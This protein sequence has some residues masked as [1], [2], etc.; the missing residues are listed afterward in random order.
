MQTRETQR[1]AVIE[2]NPPRTPAAIHPTEHFLRR[3]SNKHGT[4]SETRRNPAITGEVVEA[5]IREGT[6]S[7]G[8]GRSLLYESVVDGYEWRLVVGFNDGAPVAVTAYVPSIH[9]TEGRR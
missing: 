9:K 6:I 4:S 3:F 7:P 2:Q 5:C 1:L 8:E